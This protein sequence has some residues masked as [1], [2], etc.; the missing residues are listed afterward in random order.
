VTD[1]RIYRDYSV[2]NNDDVY[3]R[4]LERLGPDALDGSVDNLRFVIGRDDYADQRHL[5]PRPLASARY[6]SIYRNVPLLSTVQQ[7]HP[8]RK[9]IYCTFPFPYPFFDTG[10]LMLS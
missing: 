10:R 7:N 5:A 3:K 6:K 2:V 9:A 4:I 1:F 8:S